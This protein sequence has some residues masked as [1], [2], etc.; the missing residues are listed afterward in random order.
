MGQSEVGE[1]QAG[2]GE[3]I[4]GGSMGGQGPLAGL[5]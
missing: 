3:G 4:E 1:A 2:L 5:L